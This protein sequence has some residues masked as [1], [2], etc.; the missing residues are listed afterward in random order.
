M[1]R[2]SQFLTE[3]FDNPVSYQLHSYWASFGIGNMRYD[4]GITPPEKDDKSV[5][6]R[7]W[8]LDTNDFNVHWSARDSSTGAVFLHPR[9]GND[10]A[11]FQFYATIIEI[12]VDFFT[13]NPITGRQK[14][15]V[16]GMHGPKQTEIYRMIVK[17]VAERLGLRWT[18]Q[19]GRE[20]SHF[21]AYI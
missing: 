3:I 12:I 14:I 8:P 1:K 9:F 18:G 10:P 2:F 13:Q 6:K 17:K 5:K 11:A 19:V 20:E 16:R 15:S 21:W 4:V 7:L